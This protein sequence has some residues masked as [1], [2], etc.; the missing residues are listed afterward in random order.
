MVPQTKCETTNKYA[1]GPLH[2]NHPRL[3]RIHDV[4]VVF[5]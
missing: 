1:D 4:T 3:P 5:R 2:L